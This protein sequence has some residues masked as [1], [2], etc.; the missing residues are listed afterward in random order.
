MILVQ[1]ENKKGNKYCGKKNWLKFSLG[2]LLD[3]ARSSP[4]KTHFIFMSIP[5]DSQLRKSLA[6]Q[7]RTME[8]FFFSSNTV[9]LTK[10][11]CWKAQSSPVKSNLPSN[12]QFLSFCRFLH[13]G[14]QQVLFGLYGFPSGPIWIPCTWRPLSLVWTN[15]LLL[16]QMF[17]VLVSKT[18]NLVEVENCHLHVVAQKATKIHTTVH[19]TEWIQCQLL[20]TRFCHIAPTSNNATAIRPWLKLYNILG[21]TNIISMIF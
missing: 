13:L 17:L 3:S 8:K 6:Q 15:P 19:F 1:G 16:W 14:R 11:L 20:K 9:S 5:S 12:N 10:K 18:T 21:W 7:K 2:L 4:L